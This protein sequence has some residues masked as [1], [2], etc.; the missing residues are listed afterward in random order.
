MGMGRARRSVP[1]AGEVA[2]RESGCACGSAAGVGFPGAGADL[3]IVHLFKH[4]MREPGVFGIFRPVM[5]LPAGIVERLTPEQLLAILLHEANHMRRRDNLTAF[6]HML[7]E[8]VFWFHPRVWW[9]GARLVDERERACDEEVLRLGS[10]P[11]TYAEGILNICKL[12]VE[13]PSACGS[14]VTGANLKKTN[15]GDHEQPSRGQPQLRETSDLGTGSG[16]CLGSC[17][18]L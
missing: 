16:V 6:L 11:H 17:Q 8:A 15:R 9:I 2:Q 5:L 14:G 12:C 4:L 3:E 13:S 10:E 7:V 1:L 18:S